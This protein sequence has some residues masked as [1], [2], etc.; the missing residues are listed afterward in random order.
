MSNKLKFFLGIAYLLILT[1]FLYFLFSKIEISRLN[2]FIYYK[3]L[4]ISINNFI[5]DNLY[6]NLFSFFL[7]SIIWIILLGF[8]S[9]LLI[10]SGI[11]FGKWLG[12]LVS[13]ISVTIG[14]LILYIIANFFF[15]NLV[16]SYL[17][18]RFSKF[19]SLFKKNEFYYFFAFRF[20]GGL[21]IP[22]GLQNTLPVIF[23]MKKSNYFFASLFGFIPHFF[24]WNTIGSGINDFI[25]QSEEFSIINL[26]LTKEIYMPLIAIFVLVLISL[27][28]KNKIFFEKKEK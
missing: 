3:E 4:Q 28:L 22:F 20:L 8:G 11:F 24:I 12:F 9:P 26:V 18:T 13:L 15:K 1:I 10:I 19:I 7:F 2:D 14:T 25:A 23:N 5:G 17:E 16:K 21:G 6:L 27:F